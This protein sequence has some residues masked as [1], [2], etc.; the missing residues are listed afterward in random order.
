M[1][2]TRSQ[3]TRDDDESY[4]EAPSAPA[5]EHIAP[6]LS[7]L[8]GLKLECPAAIRRTLLLALSEDGR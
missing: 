5:A 6:E 7:S 8:F 2:K 4:H 3:H 1:S